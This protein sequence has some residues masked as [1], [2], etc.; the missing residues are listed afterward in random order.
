[1]AQ[2]Q[3][4][5]NASPIGVCVQTVVPLP[6][7]ACWVATLPSLNN[8]PAS[9]AGVLSPG[10]LHKK[11]SPFAI[12]VVGF[13]LPCPWSPQS[14]RCNVW[15]QYAVGGSST[16]REAVVDCLAPASGVAGAGSHIGKGKKRHCD[17]KR[18]FWWR[19]GW[20]LFPLNSHSRHLFLART[21]LPCAAIEPRLVQAAFLP[22]LN[23]CP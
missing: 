23:Y 2:P 4:L 18:R 6:A 12:L 13:G 15:S 1:M 20:L 16:H 14:P 5:E 22:S 3:E 21:S 10:G 9:R 8:T 17:K 7:Q 19:F 11:A